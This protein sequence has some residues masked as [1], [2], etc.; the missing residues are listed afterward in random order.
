MKVRKKPLIIGILILV[1]LVAMLT[2]PSEEKHRSKVKSVIAA[3]VQ[4]TIGNEIGSMNK[5]WGA[6]AKNAGL[7]MGNAMID[8]MVNTMVK[9][10]DYILFSTTNLIW[11]GESQIIGFGIFGHVFISS[12]INKMLE[13]GFL[14]Y[15][16]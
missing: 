1:A 11:Q 6:L 16:K 14:E 8:P 4:S 5:D 15:V 10:T 13:Q 3:Q 2:N 12:K 7:L 9:S